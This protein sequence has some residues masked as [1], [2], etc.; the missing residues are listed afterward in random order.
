[1]SI[2][3][4]R[5]PDANFENLPGF[6]YPAHYVDKLDGYTGLRVHYIDTK[7]GSDAP[8]FLCL[9]GQPTWSFLYRKMIPVFD[10]A[11]GRVI[12]PD[13]L[14]F[15]KSD[16]P[17][18]QSVYS[19]DF[20]RNMMLAFIAHLDL[21]NIT[22]VCQDWGGILGLTLPMDMPERF[23]R[24]LVMN[25]AIPVGE[26]P[27]EGFDNWRAFNRSQPDLDIASLMQRAVSNLSDADAAAYA[28]PY[29][30]ASYKAGVR[31]FPELVMTAPD[32][33]GVDTAKRAA[34]W[35]SESWSGETFMA[36]GMQ[37][38]VLGETQMLALK[39]TIKN[40]P[41]PMRI[42][43]AGHF[44]QESGEDIAK[45]QAWSK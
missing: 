28:A 40:C 1:M 43:D 45:L 9:H 7:P 11:G 5:T 4:L 24:L 15:G 36:I 33:P 30:D 13:W 25:T 34:T 6:D 20:H 29:P 41:D 3:A 17:V 23:D 10:A 2:N 37:D 39:E 18:D 21:R 31:Q 38:P 22:L 12:C 16:K 32:M 19:F 27:G 26:S 14:G 35:W 8:V 42:S 44:V